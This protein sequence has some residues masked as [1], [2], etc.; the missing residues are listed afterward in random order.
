MLPAITS[1]TAN[2]SNTNIKSKITALTA[3]SNIVAAASAPYINSAMYFT[4]PTS[5]S[6]ALY[7]FS[8]TNLSSLTLSTIACSVSISPSNSFTRLSISSV[9]KLDFSLS[10]LIRLLILSIL[11]A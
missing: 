3:L 8:N 4:G 2:G 1:N 10:S 11:S 9:F 5:T 7:V 6:N